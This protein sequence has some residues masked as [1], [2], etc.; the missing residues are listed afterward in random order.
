MAYSDLQGRIAI[1]T[2]AA[3]GIG[4]G[5]VEAF[6]AQGIRVAAMDID[7]AGVRALQEAHGKD[8]VLGLRVDIS[9]PAS[10]KE[11]VAAA[12][13]HFG[14]LDILVNNAALGMNAVH[15]RYQARNMQIEDVSED[16][17]QRFMMVNACGMFFMSRQAVPIFRSRKW[18]RIVNV[19]TS[20]LTMLRPGFSP[21][22]PTK[23]AVEAYSLMLARELEGSGITVNVVL[24]GGPANTQ[25]V[26]DEEGLD[27]ATLIPVAIMAPPMLGL[28]TRAGDGVTG[29]RILAIEWDTA[30]TDP[31]Q[32]KTA[33][34]AWPDLAVPLASLPKKD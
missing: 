31:T 1:V 6:V 15:P 29:R 17:W 12:V 8:A 33:S 28:F 25:M 3:A 11:Q 10:C 21:Y 2:G 26:P 16:T 5:L 19:G 22:G 34:A 32:Q 13:G 14:G 27:R 24:P 23:A 20:F 7:Q 4:K 30:I 9:D 18:G